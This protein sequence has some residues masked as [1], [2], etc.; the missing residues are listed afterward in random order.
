MH[1]FKGIAY[2]YTNSKIYHLVLYGALQGILINNK[3][4]KK[5]EQIWYCFA[6]MY[7]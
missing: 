2:K 5:K 7:L 1:L 3:S 6:K 4:Q